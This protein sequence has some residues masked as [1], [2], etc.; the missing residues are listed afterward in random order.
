[1]VT[2][3]FSKV[4]GYTYNNNAVTSLSTGETYTY[5]ADGNMISRVEGGLTYTQVFDAENRLVSVTVGGQTTQFV[6]DGDGNLVEKIKPDGS[7][8]IYVGSVYEVGKNSS[9]VVTSTIT[10]YPAGGAMRING[11]LYYVLKD[12]LGSAFVTTDGSGNIVGQMRYYA[13]GETLISS[14]GMLT[15]RLFTGQR[16]LADLNVYQFGARFYSPKLGR[17][18]SADPFI[19]MLFNPQSLNRFSYVL[20][21]PVNFVDPSGYILTSRLAGCDVDYLGSCSSYLSA[22][23]STSY[24]TGS[25]GGGGGEGGEGGGGTTSTVPTAVNVT[26]VNPTINNLYAGTPLPPTATPDYVAVP[27]PPMLTPEPWQIQVQIIP[28]PTDEPYVFPHPP[29]PIDPDKACVFCASSAPEI[30]GVWIGA[31]GPFNVAKMLLK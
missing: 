20:N 16:Q 2:T 13:S 28:S 30:G 12:R 8:T 24:N 1:M 10:Y 14:G 23:T 7:K 9:G 19:P 29:E 6:Y 22:T 26:Y 18:L 27:T 31:G 4:S 17:F 3:N 15:D 5:D 21:N 11:T 25:G